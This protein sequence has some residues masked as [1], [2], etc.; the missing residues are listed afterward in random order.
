M[1]YLKINLKINFNRLIMINLKIY[2]EINLE[3]NF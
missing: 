1:I 2:W 3:I